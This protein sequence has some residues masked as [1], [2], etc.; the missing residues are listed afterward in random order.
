VRAAEARRGVCGRL[1]TEGLEG[2]MA[3]SKV[4]DLGVK[5][6][7]NEPA[8]LLVVA[9]QC[10]GPRNEEVEGGMSSNKVT[11]FGGKKNQTTNRQICWLLLLSAAAH[12]MRRWREEW[13]AAS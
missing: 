2:E 5:K 10:S 7:N 1:R 11:D 9:A 6:S 8:D 3:S 12:A 4:T 13:R